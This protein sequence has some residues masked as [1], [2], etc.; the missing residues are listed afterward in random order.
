MGCHNDLWCFDLPTL[1]PNHTMDW[2]WL[3]YLFSIP[4]HNGMVS[5]QTGK[6]VVAYRTAPAKGTP[7]TWSTQQKSALSTFCLQTFCIDYS[8]LNF[9]KKL[10]IIN[11]SI[12]ERFQRINQ[13]LILCIW[14]CLYFVPILLVYTTLSFQYYCVITAIINICISIGCIIVAYGDLQP[15]CVQDFLQFCASFL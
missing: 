5:C 15:F 13:I 2:L 6:Y 11:I 10:Y 4:S 8:A 1:K 3:L 7:K 12:Y 14:Q 9:L